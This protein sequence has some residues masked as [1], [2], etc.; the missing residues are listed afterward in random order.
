[1]S[2]S[3]SRKTM[4]LQQVVSEIKC[5]HMNEQEQN[6][7]PA[8]DSR[9][10][11][12]HCHIYHVTFCLVFKLRAQLNMSHT[13]ARTRSLVCC[14]WCNDDTQSLPASHQHQSLAFH[15][16]STEKRSHSKMN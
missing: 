3:W 10:V 4:F 15:K 11:L 5:F 1:M 9:N 14:S 13:P 6:T 12:T 7:D 16:A 2:L 8:G